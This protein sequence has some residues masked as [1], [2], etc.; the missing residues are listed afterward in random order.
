MYG[1][2]VISKP[3]QWIRRHRSISQARPK[4]RGIYDDASLLR[5]EKKA[6]LGQRYANVEGPTAV[7]CVMVCAWPKDSDCSDFYVVQPM[8]APP[9]EYEPSSESQQVL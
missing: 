8:L 3:P 5:L 7:D 2:H 4:S 9:L 6:I 1:K